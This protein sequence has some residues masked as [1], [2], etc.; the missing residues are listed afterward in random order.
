TLSVPST[1]VVSICGRCACCASA[2]VANP[3]ALNAT[4][5][6]MRRICDIDESSLALLGLRRLFPR[7]R[8]AASYSIGADEIPRIERLGAGL[9]EGRGGRPAL[10]S[11]R[12][13]K[14]AIRRPDHCARPLCARQN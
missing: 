13:C 6:A 5:M 3:A 8:P 9:T 4:A 11:V 10:P 14:I 12:R 2:V 7:R 1:L